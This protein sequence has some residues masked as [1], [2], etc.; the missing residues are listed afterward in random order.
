MKEYAIEIV[1]TNV[2]GCGGTATMYAAFNAE[3]SCEDLDDLKRTLR[4]VKT[5][6]EDYDTEDMVAE[7]VTVFNREHGIKIEIIPTPFQYH[8]EF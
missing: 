2:D 7:A 6:G 3:P 5:F 1:E 8:I 4:E